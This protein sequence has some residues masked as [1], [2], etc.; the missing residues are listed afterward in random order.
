MLQQT[1]V[2]T[3]IPYYNEWLRRFPNFAT[4]A[5]APESD[6][7]CAWQGLGYYARARRLRAAAKLV[8]EQHGGSLPPDVTAIQAL[9]GIGRY[10][11]NAIATFA[12]DQSVPVVEANTMRVLA[13]LFDERQSIDSTTGRERIWRYAIDLLPRRHAASHNSALMDLGALVCTARGPKCRICPVQ[14]FCRSSNPERLPIKRSRPKRK[15]LTETH[16]LVVRRNRIL[17][18]QS[19]KRWP[20]M[21]ILP[22]LELDRFKRSSLNMPHVYDAVFPFTHHRVTLFVFR[23]R[24][25]NIENRQERWFAIGELNSIPIPSPHRRAITT[26]LH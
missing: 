18:H 11:A 17:L 21:W 6:V 24:R 15:R 10:T 23:R 8:Q 4:L 9:P 1:P 16:A 20:G 7:L 19:N 12:F 22:P 13:R 14:N 3:V 5:K 2:A 26:L 25:S